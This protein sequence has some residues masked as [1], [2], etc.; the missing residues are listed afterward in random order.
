VLS[1]AF[2]AVTALV[3]APSAGAAPAIQATDFF[4][5]AADHQAGAAADATTSTSLRY[6]NLSED[7]KTSIGHFAPGLLANPEAVPKCPTAQLMADNCPADTRVGTSVADVTAAGVTTVTVTGAMYNQELMGTEGGRLGIVVPAPVP[8]QPPLIL[9]AP[10]YVRTDGDYGLDGV[11]DDIPRTV[12]GLPGLPVGD[13]QIT[14]LAFT[15]FGKVQGRNFTRGP[16]SCTLHTSTGEVIG[17]DDSTPVTGPAPPSSYTPTGCDKLPF[18]PTFKMSVGSKGSTGFNGHPPLHVTVTQGAGE[19]GILANGVTL[20]PELTP[21]TAAFQTLCSEAQLKA[22]NCPAGSQAGD[23]RATSAFVANPLTGPVWLVQK[24]GSVIPTLV[25]DLKGRVPIKISIANAIIGGKQVQSTVS[26]V[27]DLPLG[28]FTLNLNGGAKGALLNKKDLCLASRSGSRFRDLKAAVTFDAQ[29]GAKTS[30][31]PRIAVEGCGPRVSGSVRK[32]RSSKPR[33]SL[34]VQRHPDASKLGNVVVVL[35]K[36]LRLVKRR[37]RGGARAKVSADLSATA[38]R[39]SGSRRLRISRLPSKG[40]AKV[41][42]KLRRG[43]V[44]PTRK[45][46][47]AL[48]RHSAT[49]LRFKVIAVDTD[50]QRFSTRGTV[51]ARR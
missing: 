15:L 21:N 2:V 7:V 9:T 11:L 1:I 20:P 27:P 24:S 12:G 10:F 30:S 48:R 41:V 40:A 22:G 49:K 42:V 39:A 5:T 37:L 38:L 43:A 31:K 18:K 34:T 4:L 28:S 50:K 51:R 47:R 23:A 19:A 45:L 25:A 29:S 46:R 3:A 16:T 44:R 36:E 33:I 26:N 6:L 17:Y 13:T 8:G 35:P 32:A 14:R